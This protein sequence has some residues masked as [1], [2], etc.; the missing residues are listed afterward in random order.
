MHWKR[1]SAPSTPPLYV[2]MC[3]DQKARCAWCI[4]CDLLGERRVEYYIHSVP[5]PVDKYCRIWMLFFQLVP[6]PRGL[7]LTRTTAVPTSRPHPLQCAGNGVVQAV[8]N[9]KMIMEVISNINTGTRARSIQ[10]CTGILRRSIRWNSKRAKE[11]EQE[12]AEHNCRT[13]APASHS[14]ASS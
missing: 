5:P 8:A 3:D 6:N 4:E 12:H 13:H 7:Y 11:N 10:D 1:E 2:T 9:P 14:G